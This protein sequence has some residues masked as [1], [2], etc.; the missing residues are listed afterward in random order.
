MHS[1]IDGVSSLLVLK[2]H[3]YYWAGVILTQAAMSWISFCSM[4]FLFFYIFAF[5]LVPTAGTKSISFE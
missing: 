1:L 5:N 3:A 4:L 2:A